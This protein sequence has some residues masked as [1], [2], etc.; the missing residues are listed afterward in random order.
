MIG[1]KQAN[2]GLISFSLAQDVDTGM[3]DGLLMNN[4]NGP[5]ISGAVDGLSDGGE[6]N[7]VELDVT[8]WH[9]FWINIEIGEIGTH[10]V[11]IYVDDADTE[12]CFEVTAGDGSDFG[13]SYLSMGLI[14]TAFNGAMDVDFYRYTEEL[15]PP[16]DP[17][18]KG[19]LFVRGNADL[20]ASIQLTDGIR[21]LNFLF[22]GQAAPTCMDAADADDSGTVDLTDPVF[23]LNFLFAGGPQPAEPLGECGIDLTIDELSCESFAGCQ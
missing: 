10:V 4:L 9:E 8:E 20:N 11:T 17:P 23:L 18:M 5:G 12:H 13:C 3:G 2:G 15:V 14:G 6:I 21:I 19:P 22:L 16:E 7:V 1:V